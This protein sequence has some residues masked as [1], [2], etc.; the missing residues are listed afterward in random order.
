MLEMII[1]KAETVPFFFLTLSNLM[2]FYG[3]L[4]T[5]FRPRWHSI[6]RLSVTVRGMS[7][8]W[9]LSLLKIHVFW[10]V[11]PYLRVNSSQ[12]FVWLWCLHPHGQQSNRTVFFAPLDPVVEYTSILRNIVAHLPKATAY[13][14]QDFNI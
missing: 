6:L 7:G 2:C 10:D 12:R 8:L 13:I 14:T 9:N 5:N 11:T 1:C 3:Q 4:T